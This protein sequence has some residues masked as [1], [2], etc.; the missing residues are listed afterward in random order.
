MSVKISAQEVAKLRKMTGSGFMDC[1][2]ALVEAEGDYDKAVEIL[3][4]KGQKLSAK[5]ADRETN[6]GA[7][8]ALVNADQTKGIVLNL[9]C[10][11]DF[12]AMTESF[13]A[14]ANEFAQMALASFPANLEELLALKM[15]NG[16]TISEK[17][18]EQIGVIGEKLAI[19]SYA[20]LEAPMVVSYIHAGNKIGVL[21]G[22]T[23]NDDAFNEAGRSVAMQVAAMNPLAINKDAVDASVV[24][25]EIEIGKDIARNEGKPEDLVERIAMGKLNKFFSENTLLGQKFVKNPKETVQSYLN[26]VEKGLTVTD[27][28][29]VAVGG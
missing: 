4:K 20:R 13:V 2:K 5:R 25:K 23:K 11:T 19:P 10:E 6:E 28:K 17:L 16:L 22:L 27:F 7:A 9:S 12:V 29:R 8:I 26:S 14:M 24:E 1:K 15:E 18:I 3:R 21:L